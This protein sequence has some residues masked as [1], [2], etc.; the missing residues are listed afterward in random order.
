MTRR[1]DRGTRLVVASH[2]P[3][4]VREILELVA[5]YG[6]SVVSA[7]ELGLPEPEETGVDVRRQ[8]QAEGAGGGAGRGPAG[9]RRRLRASR[10]RRSAG[11][12]ASI[13]RAGPA[14]PR[15]SRS[16]CGGWPTSCGA[17]RPG[18]ARRGRAPT[19]SAALC[20][21]WPDG[22]IGSCSR[23]RFTAIS[24]GRRAG[25][26]VSAM[27]RCS[28]ADGHTLTFGEMEPM[29]SMRSP[30]A[31]A[32]SST[33]PRLPRRRR[34]LT[35]ADDAGFGVYIHWPFCASKCPYCDFNSH[36]RAGGIDEARFLRAYLRELRHW[37][38][39]APARSVGSIFFGGGTPSLMSAATVA[40]ILDAIAQPVERRR[41]R[42]DHAGGQSIERGGRR[43][44][45][46]IAP[47]AST[48]SRSACSRST[49]PTCGHWAGCTRS[50]RRWPRSMSRAR[51]FERFSF[52]L[53]YARPGQTLP[54]WQQRADAGA[55]AG[56]P[57]PVALSAHHRGRDAVR[58]APCPRQAQGAGQ[59]AGAR[60]LR[61]DAGADGAGRPAGLRDLQPRRPGRG[62]PPQ[63]ALLALRRVCRHRAGRARPRRDR[64]HAPRH[65]DRA[66]AGALGRARRGGRP[67]RLEEAPRSA[68]PSRP[69]RRCSWGCG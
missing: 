45:A 51:H 35:R 24:S 32:P 63:P 60:P 27:I 31:P 56:G 62:V 44:S 68:G 16:P 8:R 47:P 28:F 14:R 5:P 37:A 49:M 33:S 9:A 58:R 13:R 11:R 54:A 3:G 2:N 10:S 18:T 61:A 15:T 7:G 19:S 22:E 46:A 59:R 69:T 34:A 12:P 48:A 39:L 66:P 65:G 1:L 36:V 17:R 4:K 67:R 42:R 41:R 52:D 50:R 30:T 38:E 26:R 21:A 6:L 20:L 40:A 55:G 23:A 53:I 64:R 25:A 57:A 29:P 43:A